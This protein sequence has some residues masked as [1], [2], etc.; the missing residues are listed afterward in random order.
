MRSRKRIAFGACI[1]AAVLLVLPFLL[2]LD[3]FIPEIERIASEQLKA[4]VK[5]NSLSMSFLP[6]PHLTVK[7]IAV[8]KKPFLE[9]QKVINERFFSHRN[10][11]DGPVRKPQ[12]RHTQGID[13][14][15][16]R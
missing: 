10:A 8:G 14:D 11:L 3:H 1:A 4:P 5:V 9:V 2:P 13:L 6:L 16:L 7:G 12:K 15:Q